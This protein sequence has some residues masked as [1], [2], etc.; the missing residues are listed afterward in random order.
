MATLMSDILVLK[1]ECTTWERGTIYKLSWEYKA[2][3]YAK[4]KEMKLYELVNGQ[5]NP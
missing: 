2:I 4:T 1:A 5:K 3:K